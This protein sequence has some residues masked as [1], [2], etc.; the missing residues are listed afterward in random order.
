[1]RELTASVHVTSLTKSL[2]VRAEAVAPHSAKRGD[3]KIHQGWLICPTRADKGNVA[4][5]DLY[6]GSTFH[7]P[8]RYNL[9]CYRGVRKSG[10]LQTFDKQL[11]G[12]VL[13]QVKV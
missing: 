10:A 1:M 4:L 9:I 11:R 2:C 12:S 7:T 8:A 5:S 6:R 13:A 3:Q